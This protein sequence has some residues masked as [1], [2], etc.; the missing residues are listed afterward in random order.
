MRYYEQQIED[1]EMKNHRFVRLESVSVNKG[2]NG[3][4]SRRDCLSISFWYRSLFSF[5]GS[6]ES[7]KER[8]KEEKGGK[9]GRKRDEVRE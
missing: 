3:N 2:T 5:P 8:K 4:R 7:D 6:I 1:Q 9:R